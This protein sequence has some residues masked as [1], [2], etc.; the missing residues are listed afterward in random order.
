MY[1]YA[2]KKL[3]F[4]SFYIRNLTNFMTKLQCMSYFMS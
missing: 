1:K 3:H 2:I 4:M